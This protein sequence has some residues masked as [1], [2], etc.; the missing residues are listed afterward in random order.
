MQQTYDKFPDIKLTVARALHYN[1]WELS[2]KIS[3]L[4]VNLDI[5]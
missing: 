3:V 5:L 2:Y 1:T 4:D